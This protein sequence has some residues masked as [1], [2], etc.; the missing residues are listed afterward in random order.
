[1]RPLI[2]LLA[3]PVPGLNDLSQLVGGP[4]LTFLSLGMLGS[5]QSQ[6]S[7][8]RARSAQR[9]VGLLQEAFA[10]ADSP[11]RKSK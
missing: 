6:E 3:S 2:N 8:Q 7:V 1:M 11:R 4:E 10:F 9:V 5:S